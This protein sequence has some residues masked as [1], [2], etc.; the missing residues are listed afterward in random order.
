MQA[1]TAISQSRRR[2]D[3]VLSLALLCLMGSELLWLVTR[4][5]TV[6]AFA[7]GVLML[8]VLLTAPR[9]GIRETYLLTIVTVLSMLVWFTVEGPVDVIAEVFGIVLG[10]RRR[11]R[12]GGGGGGR[13]RRG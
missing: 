10:R 2:S 7:G 4:S 1:D 11:E 12:V 9:F 8:S 13:G 3:R 5:D 6:E